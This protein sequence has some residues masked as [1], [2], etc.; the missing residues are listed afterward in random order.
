MPIAGR[1]KRTVFKIGV[2]PKQ[3]MLEGGRQVTI[4]P[5]QPADREKL[6]RFFLGIPAADRF[7]VHHD[8]TD[9]DLIDRWTKHADYFRALPLVAISDDRIVGD[10]VLLRGLG[11][12]RAHTA[13]IRVLLAPPFR[14]IGLTGA[15]LAELCRI[16]DEARLDLVFLEVVPDRDDELQRAARR[17]GFRKVTSV[18]KGVRDAAGRP[19]ELVLLGRR[20]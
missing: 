5:L 4:R 16:A 10:S 6:R 14:R 8:V 11:P 9:P 19:K 15:L 13:L 1:G 7:L 3:L 18:P 17:L 2:Y 12:A 20:P